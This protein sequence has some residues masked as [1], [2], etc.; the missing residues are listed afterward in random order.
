MAALEMQVQASRVAADDLG[1][2]LLV[3]DFAIAEEIEQTFQIASEKRGSSLNALS[4]PMAL[5]NSEKI[6]M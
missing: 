4:D 5:D 2:E 6:G 1:F 3:F